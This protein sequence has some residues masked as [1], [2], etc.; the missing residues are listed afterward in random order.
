MT[1]TN[2]LTVYNIRFWGIL[3]ERDFFFLDVAWP[4]HACCVHALDLLIDYLTRH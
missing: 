3:S 2:C 4:Y 1:F